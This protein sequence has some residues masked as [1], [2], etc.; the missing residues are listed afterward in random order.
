[1]SGIRGRSRA[2]L[3]VCTLAA[4]GAATNQGH[5]ASPAGDPFAACS[6][7]Q[8]VFGGVNYADTELE[9]WLARNLANPDNMIGSYQQDRWDDGGAKGLVASWS[10][11]DGLRRRPVQRRGGPVRQRLLH[12][13]LR[14]PHGRPRREAVPSLPVAESV[15]SAV[16]A[17]LRSLARR[18]LEVYARVAVQDLPGE[19]VRAAGVDADRGRDR[20]VEVLAAGPPPPERDDPVSFAVDDDERVVLEEVCSGGLD[21]HERR[22]TLRPDEASRFRNCAQFRGVRGREAEG[23]AEAVAEV[24][25][26]RVPQLVR[27]CGQVAAAVPDSAEGAADAPSKRVR[28]TAPSTL[29]ETTPCAGS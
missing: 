2:G 17:P 8:D 28:H 25:Q 13:R 20:L 23:V 10:F 19:E 14:G 18:R 7:G 6:I 16:A 3:C 24:T 26:T 11:K 12:R 22:L 5:E 9:P 27:E 4:A 15:P 1:V 21:R 29:V